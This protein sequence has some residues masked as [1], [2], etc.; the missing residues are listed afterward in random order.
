MRFKYVETHLICT[1]PHEFI[2]TAVTTIHLDP[3][4]SR[5]IVIGFCVS[6]CAQNLMGKKEKKNELNRQL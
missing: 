4:I 2:A 1:T 6:L 5:H 3:V